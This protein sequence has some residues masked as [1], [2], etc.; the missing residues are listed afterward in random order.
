M[1]SDLRGV[2]E[3]NEAREFKYFVYDEGRAPDC[4]GLFDVYEPYDRKL[5]AR[6][7]TRGRAGVARAVDAAVTAFHAWWRST[8]ATRTRLSFKAGREPQ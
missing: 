6:V 7:A 3:V 1:M 5:Y 2:T 8:L 4:N